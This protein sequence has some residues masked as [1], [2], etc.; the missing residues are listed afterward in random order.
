MTIKFS[1][2]VSNAGAFLISAGIFAAL[3]ILAYQGY[4]W[5][6]YGEWISLPLYKVLQHFNIDFT[7]LVDMDWQ[8]AKK[9]IFWVLER[10]FSF[11]ISISSIV[12][13]LTLH[14]STKTIKW[15]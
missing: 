14:L 4:F 10:P 2:K 15:S 3:V 1:E 11:V 8:G 9:F 6:R 13:G 5:F 7:G 12:I